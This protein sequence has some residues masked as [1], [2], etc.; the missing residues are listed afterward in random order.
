MKKLLLFS[1]GLP[2]LI[3]CGGNQSL[4]DDPN[5]LETATYQ[6]VIEKYEALNIDIKQT[7]NQLEELAISTGNLRDGSAQS[8]YD[9]FQAAVQKDHFPI[10]GEQAFFNGLKQIANFPPNL[11]C[12]KMMDLSDST[13]LSSRLNQYNTYLGQELQQTRRTGKQPNTAKP[14]LKA[15]RME[16]FENQYIQF[17]M[18]SAIAHRTSIENPIYNQ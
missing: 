16:D 15:Y 13:V 7:K 1:F 6:C 4:K 14:V 2:L 17:L 11:S 10:A 18:L 5:P 3:S 9:M 12:D 8:Y